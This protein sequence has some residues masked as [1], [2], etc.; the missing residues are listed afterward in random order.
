MEGRIKPSLEGW[1]GRWVGVWGN[2]TADN[3]RKI[4]EGREE[5]KAGH[6]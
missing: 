1:T 6:V 3:K 2:G 5:R 4:K